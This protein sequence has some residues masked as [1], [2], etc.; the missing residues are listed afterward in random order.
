MAA[1]RISQRRTAWTRTVLTERGDFIES[2]AICGRS[3]DVLAFGSAELYGEKLFAK[4]H[5]VGSGGMGRLPTSPFRA[6]FSMFSMVHAA[7]FLT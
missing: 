2:R 4:D 5:A 1:C 6:R 3:V 7:I